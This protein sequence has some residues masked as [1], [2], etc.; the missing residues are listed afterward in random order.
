[1]VKFSP[2]TGPRDPACSAQRSG[3]RSG[4]EILKQ[5]EAGSSKSR[6]PFIIDSVL[7]R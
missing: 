3:P 1:M 4:P 6:Y 5:A 7:S 2:G